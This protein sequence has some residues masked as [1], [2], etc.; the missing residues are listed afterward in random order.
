MF[1]PSGKTLLCKHFAADLAKQG[2][3][4]V[5]FISLAAAKNQDIGTISSI[6]A[7]IDVA[8]EIDIE[9]TQDYR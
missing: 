8:S 7:V 3:R 4:V 1:S 5:Y 6:P 9:G 2:G